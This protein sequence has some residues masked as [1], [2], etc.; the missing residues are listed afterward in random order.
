M[1]IVI[2]G[3]GAPALCTREGITVFLVFFRGYSCFS[4]LFS[5]SLSLSEGREGGNFFSF[6][7]GGLT[8]S[9]SGPRETSASSF[10]VLWRRSS[11]AEVWLTS[12]WGRGLLA[13]PTLLPLLFLPKPPPSNSECF[14]SFLFL[15]HVNRFKSPRLT[16]KVP[17]LTSPPPRHTYKDPL[18]SLP[19]FCLFSSLL[20]LSI[21]LCSEGGRDGGIQERGFILFRDGKRNEMKWKAE[22]RRN[23]AFFEKELK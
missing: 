17:A 15:Y 7:V 10:G 22:K 11:D 13:L 1:S 14:E 8:L 6:T 20:S 16:C 19:Y 18:P 21:S 2:W 12:R 9:L 5:L 4:F 3:G 23:A